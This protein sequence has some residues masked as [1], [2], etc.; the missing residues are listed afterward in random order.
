MFVKLVG[1]V[2]LKAQDM[3]YFSSN[4]NLPTL[5]VPLFLGIL[6]CGEHSFSV[7]W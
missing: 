5:C 3:S 7:V 4:R 2:L 1:S 6:D